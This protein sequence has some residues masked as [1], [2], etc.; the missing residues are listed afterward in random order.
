M[1]DAKIALTTNTPYLPHTMVAML[2]VLENAKRPVSVHILGDELSDAAKKAI[3]DACKRN[4]AADLVFHDLEE[5][6]PRQRLLGNWSRVILGRLWIPELIDGRVLY[7][8][9][10][11]Y[12]FAD[13]SP[14]FEMDMGGSLLGCVRDIG[15]L[16]YFD[17]HRKLEQKPESYR[18]IEDIMSPFPRNDY[19][20]SG[21]LLFDCDGI[22]KN[23]EILSQIT[24][25]EKLE[26]YSL[27]DQ[28]HL[29]IVFKNRTLLL[30][31]SWNSCYGLERRGV[32]ISKNVLPPEEAHKLESPKI[33][34]YVLGPKPFHAFEA[35]W[36]LKTSVVF[37]RLRR[38]VEYR[39]NAKRL[40]APYKAAIDE[41]VLAPCHAPMQGEKHAE[42]GGSPE[43]CSDS[44][45]RRHDQPRAR[46]DCHGV[47]D[48]MRFGSRHSASSRR[49]PDQRRRGKVGR[50][51]PRTC[52]RQPAPSRRD[53]D[54]GRGAV[55]VQRSQ[56]SHWADARSAVR[57]MP[58]SLS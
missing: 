3:E 39:H 41:A 50:G 13:I 37:K 10:D 49:W 44:A 33:I 22:R 57:R 52:G 55:E 4:G 23:K 17:K 11:T 30:H 5:I 27:P 28:D 46:L 31:P 12:T 51:L 9:G 26:N 24:R 21:V 36:L 15:Q 45:L 42:G 16:S 14:L 43:Q 25:I 8:D 40:L 35:R 1:P 2:S 7:L 34:H 56:D 48:R 6:L 20:N 58:R 54:A 38:F 47:G 19:F 53:G 18:Y 29:N 32:R